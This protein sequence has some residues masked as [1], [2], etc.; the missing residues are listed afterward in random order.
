MPAR[1]T[2]AERLDRE[3]AA[4]RLEEIAKAL[5]NEETVDV[6]VGNK[7]ISLTPPETVSFRV[8]V[9]EKNKLLRGDRET[10]EIEIDW[11]PD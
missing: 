4:T 3:T 7:S 9:V 10:I 6:R 2:Q 8:D 5:R 1:T 11:K